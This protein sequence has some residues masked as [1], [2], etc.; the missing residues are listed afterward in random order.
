MAYRESVL[1]HFKWMERIGAEGLRPLPLLTCSIEELIEYE[2]PLDSKIAVKAPLHKRP[3][4]RA[5]LG[6]LITVAQCLDHLAHDMVARFSS[7]SPL[8]GCAGVGVLSHPHNRTPSFK[9][10]LIH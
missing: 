1:R 6:T 3:G 2:R 4:M 8:R 5:L 9:G 10:D 7:S